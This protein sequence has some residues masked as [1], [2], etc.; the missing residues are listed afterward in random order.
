MS[1]ALSNYAAL[2]FEAVEAFERLETPDQVVGHL[3][4]ALA[5]FGYTGFLITSTPDASAESERQTFLDGWPNRF[6]EHYSEQHFYT[7]DPIAAHCR[8]TFDPFEWSEVRVDKREWPRAALVMG[9]AG[10][11]GL[12]QGYSIPIFRADELVDTVSMAGEC[13]DFDQL[14]KR[15]VHIIG[16]YAHAKAMS[17]I[18]KKQQTGPKLLSSAER[19]A[20]TWVAMGKS[21]WEISVILGISE[22]AVIQRVDRA[23]KKLGAVNRTQAAVNALRRREITI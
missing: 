18:A 15:A 13:P 1:G 12:R 21:S 7:D 20:M 6:N 9:A 10:E 5:K 3:R 11:F 22:S 16:L 19:E 2:A 14:A 23:V 17:L 8:H 4:S